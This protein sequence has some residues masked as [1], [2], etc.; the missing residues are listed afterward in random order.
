MQRIYNEY[1]TIYNNNY[2]EIRSIINDTKATGAIVDQ[3]KLNNT[4]KELEGLYNE[5]KNTDVA[6]LRLKTLYERLETFV[7]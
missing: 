6:N 1:T 7:Q 2:K 5:S 4:L 3:I